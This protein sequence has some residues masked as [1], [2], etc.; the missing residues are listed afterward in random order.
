MKREHGPFRTL[1]DF[2][3]LDFQ[4]VYIGKQALDYTNDYR[5]SLGLPGLVWSD[6]LCRIAEVHSRNMAAGRVPFGHDG[7]QQRFRSYPYRS[8][9]SAENVAHN[10]GIYEVAKAAVDGWIHSEGHRRNL[11]GPF[12][13]CGIGV[14]CSSDGTWYLTQLFGTPGW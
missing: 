2:R 11:V 10:K 3:R 8:S 13:V 9:R 14:A 6:E 12:I 4:P 7:A 1:A 5:A